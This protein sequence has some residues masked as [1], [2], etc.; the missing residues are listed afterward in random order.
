M[1]G[2]R[3]RWDAGGVRGEDNGSKRW[4]HTLQKAEAP[5]SLGM[6]GQVH[7]DLA[8]KSTVLREDA[9]VW[10][11]ML[12]QRSSA[13]RTG[14]PGDWG[15]LPKSPEDGDPVQ[16]IRRWHRGARPTQARPWTG[17]RY[18][19]R[20]GGWKFPLDLPKCIGAIW[21]RFRVDIQAPDRSGDSLAEFPGALRPPGSAVKRPDRGLGRARPLL[22]SL[23]GLKAW[24]RECVHQSGS[25][26]PSLIF[27]MLKFS[28]S[29]TPW[30]AAITLYH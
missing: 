1:T 26:H 18:C 6:V 15:A 11:L 13:T 5:N 8:V 2:Y 12:F 14:A 30:G 22:V 10:S 27:A 16:A 3:T 17:G 9:H 28:N 23:L 20:W 24:R 19:W 7:P 25:K 29:L 21:S 4:R